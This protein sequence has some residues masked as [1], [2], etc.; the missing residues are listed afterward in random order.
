[1]R[2]RGASLRCGGRGGRLDVFVLGF[3]PFQREGSVTEYD[4]NGRRVAG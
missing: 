3:G 4:Q 2:G 1:M